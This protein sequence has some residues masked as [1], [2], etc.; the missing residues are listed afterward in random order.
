MSTMIRKEAA[1]LWYALKI[2]AGTGPDAGERPEAAKSAR[3]EAREGERDPALVVIS[4]AGRSNVQA[5]QR[6]QTAD[7]VRPAYALPYN[8]HPVEPRVVETLAGG[9]AGIAV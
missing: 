5:Q 6:S 3:A 8:A 9:D 2:A 1:R 4:R 7:G